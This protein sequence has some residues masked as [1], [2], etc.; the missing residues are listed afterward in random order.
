MLDS[1]SSSS[2]IRFLQFLLPAFGESFKGTNYNDVIII[3]I[4]PQYIQPS[5]NI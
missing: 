5:G 4:M 3:T 1:L 2:D